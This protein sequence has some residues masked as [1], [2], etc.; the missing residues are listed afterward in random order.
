LG[1]SFEIQEN[2]SQYNEAFLRLDSNIIIITMFPTFRYRPQ[3]PTY[4]V[5]FCLASI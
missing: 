3:C 1:T 2:I 5:D 4:T